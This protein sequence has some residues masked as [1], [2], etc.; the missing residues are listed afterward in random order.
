M[1]L[2]KW[3]C[4]LLILTGFSTLEARDYPELLSVGAG[5][6]NFKLHPCNNKTYLL[7]A[8]YKWSICNTLFRP[9]IGVFTGGFKSYFLY[10]GIAFDLFVTDHF[11]ITPS[12]SP[13]YYHFQNGGRNLGYPVEFRSCLELAWNFTCHQRLGVQ[14][15]HLSNASIGKKNPGVNCLTAFFSFPLHRH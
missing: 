13:G 3:A 15:Y 2:K 1:L 6:F 8:E 10:A 14:V 4:L 9:Q 7:Q 5:V 12:F 11:V